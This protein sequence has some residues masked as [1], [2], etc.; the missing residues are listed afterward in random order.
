MLSKIGDKPYTLYLE[1][2]PNCGNKRTLDEEK[3]YGL[4]AITGGG[5][6]TTLLLGAPIV[7]AMGAIG[8][9][10]L[11]IAGSISG[12]AAARLIKMNYEYLNKL[13]QKNLFTCPNCGCSKL[14]K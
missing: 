7:G 14:V 5:I 13:S 2:C 6:L 10:K 8:L 11:A 3:L 12:T 9:V 1:E 4:A